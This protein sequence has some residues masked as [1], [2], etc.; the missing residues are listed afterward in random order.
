MY[1][2]P[3]VCVCLSLCVCVYVFLCVCWHWLEKF[4]LKY[5]LIYFKSGEKKSGGGGR[6][7][8][9]D[10]GGFMTPYWKK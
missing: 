3:L 10:F 6:E 4:G 2:N 7:R 8:R 9:K 5:T 1:G